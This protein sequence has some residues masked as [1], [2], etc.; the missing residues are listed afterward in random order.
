MIMRSFMAN[1]KKKKKKFY[2][3][4]LN[5][6]MEDINLLRQIIQELKESS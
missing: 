1:L 4:L 3:K 2:K 5:R 6:Y